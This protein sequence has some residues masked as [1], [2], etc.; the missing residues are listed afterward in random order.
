[1]ADPAGAWSWMVMV[2]VEVVCCS[3]SLAMKL[4]NDW[5]TC[6]QRHLWMLRVYG[7]KGGISAMTH[8]KFWIVVCSR[9]LSDKDE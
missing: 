6:I 8:M 4:V 9:R 5:S 2:E 7:M 1:M 3:F